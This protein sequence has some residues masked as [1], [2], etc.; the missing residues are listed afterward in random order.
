MWSSGI[1]DLG[2]TSAEADPD[3]DPIV[4]RV[5]KNEDRVHISRTR[6]FVQLTIP[7]WQAVKTEVERQIN[8]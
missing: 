2:M 7:E 3:P 8:E 4:V 1:S 6:G 5:V